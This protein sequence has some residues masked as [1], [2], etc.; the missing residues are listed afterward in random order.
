MQHLF[1][2]RCPYII[3][4][5]GDNASV[6]AEEIPIGLLN[7]D[8]QLQPP[9]EAISPMAIVPD[10]LRDA[11]TNGDSHGPLYLCCAFKEGW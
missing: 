10:V 1:R 5:A 4:V 2:S 3:D 11:W 8:A 9:P 7:C 6:F